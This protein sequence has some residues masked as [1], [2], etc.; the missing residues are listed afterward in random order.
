MRQFVE[1]FVL[2]REEE[3]EEEE[4]L[5]QPLALGKEDPPPLGKEKVEQ[6]ELE[7]Q[8]FEDDALRLCCEIE[9]LVVVTVA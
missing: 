8:A 2:S 9:D 5:R 7:V 1:F 4:A 6:E 3:E